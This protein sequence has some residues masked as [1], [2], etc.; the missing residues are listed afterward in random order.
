MAANAHVNSFLHAV[1]AQ[2]AATPPR[3]HSPL[4]PKSDFWHWVR[5]ALAFRAIH[6]ESDGLTDADG[7]AL[8]ITAVDP[9]GLPEGRSG[10][11]LA[12]GPLGR[13]RIGDVAAIAHV[14]SR[15]VDTVYCYVY[16]R[17]GT[18]PT[19]EALT[20]GTFLKAQQRLYAFTWSERD[21]GAWLVTIAR[22]L[23]ADHLKSSRF[24]L[25]GATRDTPG[26]GDGENSPEESLQGSR[27]NAALIEAVRRLNPQQQECV[28]LRFL[29]G[30]SVAE[31]ARVMGKNEVA[32]KTLQYRAVRTLTRLL[33][34]RP[35]EPSAPHVS[36]HPDRSTPD[37]AGELPPAAPD[38]SDPWGS[39]GSS[40]TGTV[41]TRRRADA[42]AQVLAETEE[43]TSPTP[44]AASDTELLDL[45]HHLGEIG[46]R[47][48][49]AAV[50]Q[51]RLLNQ[52][53]AVAESSGD[54][55]QPS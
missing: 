54:S 12:P 45:A 20:V 3:N 18:A 25:E 48:R 22:N 15:F 2:L 11:S 24:R 31:T 14:G 7:S 40:S 43:T 39:P 10:S 8:P 26:V 42:F 5:A 46:T 53:R 23:V 33:P 6:A 51:T 13:V 37:S 21:L 44:T 36:G 41:R 34:T 1:R 9:T 35:A 32:I 38:R 50:F 19:A 27:S 4:S 52:L 47:F 30:L 49:S 29:L 28:T 17:V 16:F 55:E